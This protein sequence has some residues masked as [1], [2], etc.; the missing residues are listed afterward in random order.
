[1]ALTN[2]SDQLLF[3]DMKEDR[4]ERFERGIPKISCAGEA[5]PK[6]SACSV[7]IHGIHHSTMNSDMTPSRLIV[8]CF[9]RVSSLE[10]SA[11][12]TPRRLQSALSP[13]SE[14]VGNFP[15]HQ[16]HGVIGRKPALEES[17]AIEPSKI[18]RSFDQCALPPIL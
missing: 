8:E 1:M 13:G 10:M 11:S 3:G 18:V 4:T 5:D 12:S 9:R 2:D 14:S 7:V 16:F 15:R 17:C 6:R